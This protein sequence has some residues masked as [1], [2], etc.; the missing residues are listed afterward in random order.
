MQMNTFMT[1][2]RLVRESKPTKAPGRP[3][4]TPQASFERQTI[5]VVPADNFDHHLL[6]VLVVDD[7]RANTDTMSMLVARWGHDVRR[8]YDGVTGLALA[9]AFRPDV[10]LLDML[11]PGVNGFEVAR[12]VRRQDRLQSCFIIAVSGR[13]DA[14]HQHHCYEAGVDLFLMKPVEPANMQTLL[15]L[16]S[17]HARRSNESLTFGNAC[18]GFAATN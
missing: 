1:K 9:A 12:Q 16:E 10:L 13:T 8:A 17:D 15:G 5:I 18:S 11:M 14:P 4:G 7:H 3:Q 2:D 6:R